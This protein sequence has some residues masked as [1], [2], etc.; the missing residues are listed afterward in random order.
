MTQPKGIQIE[1]TDTRIDVG[2]TVACEHLSF[3]AAGSRLVLTGPPAAAI[4]AAVCGRGSVSA[5]R[6]RMDGRDVSSAQHFGHVGVAPFELP[7]PLRDSVL[8]FVTVS[9][10]LAGLGRKSAASAAHA[11]LAE[12]GLQGMEARKARS[13]APHERRA[14]AI[15]QALLPTA[16]V[17]FAESPLA[18][19]D[20]PEARMVLATLGKVCTQ[21][22][23]VATALRTDPS[24]PERELLLGADCVAILTSNGPGFLGAPSALLAG[25]RLLAVTVRGHEAQFESAARAAGIG[26]SGIAPRFVLQ[27]QEGTTTDTLLQLARQSEATLLEVAPLWD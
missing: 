24:S 13:L 11:A 17:L 14:V 23:V 19:L 8:A 10:R 26:I 6:L 1:A 18:G 16:H 27:L 21:R 22:A 7:M 25:S 15:A 4:A 12:L 9:F 2:G 3:T 20:T 5:G